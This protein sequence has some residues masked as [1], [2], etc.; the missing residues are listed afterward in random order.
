MKNLLLL[1]FIFS[2]ILINAQ[3]TWNNFTLGSTS[4]TLRSGYTDVVKTDSK[5][6][7]WVATNDGLTKIDGSKYTNF[8]T[9]NG[10][11]NNQVK[12][13]AIQ[14]NNDNIWIGTDNG[15][16][17]YDGTKWKNYTTTEGL[18]SNSIRAINFDKNG[19]AWIGTFSGLSIQNGNAWKNYDEKNGMISDAVISI[20]FDKNGNAWLGGSGALPVTKF[21]GTKFKAYYKSD[22]ITDNYALS[23]LVD[24]KGIVWLGGFD[25][26]STFDGTK[27]TANTD[28]KNV[29]DIAEDKLGN[30]WLAGADSP[31]GKILKING[32]VITIFDKINGKNMNSWN[33]MTIDKNNKKWIG[34]SYALYSYDDTIWKKFQPEGGLID[35]EI[36][37]IKADANGNMNIGT[38][39]G[40][41][42]VINND[43][44]STNADNVGVN[45]LRVSDLLFEGKNQWIAN[46][47]AGEIIYYNGTTYEKYD[48][49]NVKEIPSYYINRIFKDSKGNKW[50]AFEDGLVKYNGTK[51]TQYKSELINTK[52]KSITEDK[53]GNIWAATA[54]GISVFDGTTWKSFTKANTSAIK[55]DYFYCCFTDKD[56]NI[57]LGSGS[58]A[59]K[60]DGTTWTQYSSAG[61]YIYAIN[62]DVQ[63]N[64]WFGSYYSVS[65]FDGTKWTKFTTADG[66]ISCNQV[67]AISFDKDGN[68]WFGTDKGLSIYGKNVTI[69]S[70]QGLYEETSI[71]VFPNPATDE[72]IIDSKVNFEQSATRLV[73]VNGQ[74]YPVNLS[75]DNRLDLSNIPNGLYILVLK[76]DKGYTTKKFVKQ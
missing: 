70:L 56:G 62:Q 64:I 43:W 28:L 22:G 65:K 74:N 39:N 53:K 59:Y 34:S 51:W 76:T 73:S 58:G 66:L 29:Q 24:S 21:D 33:C 38:Y 20:A 69:S 30:I 49:L 55:N 5:G 35:D 15:V 4:K 1:L 72:L 6:V 14:P 52:V 44:I 31:Y 13:L 16:Q 54:A 8:S 3:S 10:L 61:S 26:Y 25:G 71:T 68:V 50:F 7:V 27:W 63:G 46:E 32:K 48:W 23:L 19:N 41:S 17:V 2:T 57:W 67:N 40:I 12:A 47:W 18:V 75:S 60:Y 36:R 11:L 42:K 45:Y 9:K 37:V